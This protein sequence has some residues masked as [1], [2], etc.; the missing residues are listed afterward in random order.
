MLESLLA[1]V[2]ESVEA[3]KSVIAASTNPDE[4]QQLQLV[5]SRGLGIC[6]VI[7]AEM[8]R[9]G[10]RDVAELATAAGKYVQAVSQFTAAAEGL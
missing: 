9:V 1:E 6:D 8:A 4:V 2:V 10:E 7:R 3:L 5:Q